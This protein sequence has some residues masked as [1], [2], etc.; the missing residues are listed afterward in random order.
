MLTRIMSIKKVTYIKAISLKD[1]KDINNIIE[2]IN[3]GI[4]LIVRI[5]PL[6]EKSLDELKEVIDSIYEFIKNIDGDIARL[7][8]ERIIITPPSVKI[9]RNVDTLINK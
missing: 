8:E 6:A 1:S 4:V 2:D 5:T 3:N 7:G 9:L